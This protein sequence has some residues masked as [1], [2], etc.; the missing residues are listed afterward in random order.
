MKNETPKAL[1]I[2]R[3]RLL[4]PTTGRDE[5]GALFITPEG[6]IAPVPSPLPAASKMIVI[7]RDNLTVTPG[8]CDVHVHFRDPGKTEAEDLLSGA[9][10]AAN[11]GF[12]R[13]VTMPNTLPATDTPDLVRRARNASLPVKIYPSACG[14]IGRLGEACANLEQLDQAGAVCFTDDGSMIDRPEVM[15]TVM[16]RAK[17][18][19][20][21]VMDH[22]VRPDIQKGGIIR[23]CPVAHQYNLPIFPAEAE[24]E[25]VKDDIARCRETGCAIHLQHLSCAE[26]VDLIAQA[27]AE[28]LPVTGEVT[29]HH[30]TLAAEDIPGNDGNWRM[31]PPLGTRADVEGLRKGILD[32]TLT[33]FATDHAPHT[34]ESKAKG[35]AAAPFGIIGLETAVAVSWDTMV[36]QCGMAPLQWAANWIVHP[37]RLIG[38]TPPTLAEGAMAELAIFDLD[39]PWV[40]DPDAFASKS[41]D[42]PWA[43]QTL[44]GVAIATYRKGKLRMPTR[45]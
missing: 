29:P 44:R 41:A 35:F 20:R 22:A 45:A 40:V 32:G 38:L 6:R 33:I 9:A 15:E 36:R 30:M 8:L 7:D 2:P 23:D 31:N 17:A 43:G 10:A 21:V 18:L 34:R 1:Y 42:T 11:G 27:Q 14:T 4:D 3:A 19:G 24:I 12:T 5:I 13:V 25:A 28:G 39:Q 16:R 37:N 26:S